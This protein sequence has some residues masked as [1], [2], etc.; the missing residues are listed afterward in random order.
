MT[1]SLPS[2]QGKASPE[3]RGEDLRPCPFCGPGT[4]RW[5]FKVNGKPMVK[6]AACDTNAPLKTWSRESAVASP[7][8]EERE[9]L[10]EYEAVRATWDRENRKHP[11]F[12]DDLVP[13]LAE[14]NRLVIAADKLAALLRAAR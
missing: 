12:G 9:R 10:A 4:K 6:C 14:T 5:R 1:S 11:P 2:G 7:T 13:L 3:Q 8:D